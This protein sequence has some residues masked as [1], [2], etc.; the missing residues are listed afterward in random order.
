M[1]ASEIARRLRYNRDMDI[2]TLNEIDYACL[3]LTWYDSLPA[4]DELL[5]W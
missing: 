5:N 2:N 1:G 4:W 3:W